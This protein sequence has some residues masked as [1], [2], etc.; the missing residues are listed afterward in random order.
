MNLDKSLIETENPNAAPIGT[1]FGLF[2]FGDANASK[3]FVI[4]LAN[5]AHFL[6]NRNME[7]TS[8]DRLH[9]FPKAYNKI[10][11]IPTFAGI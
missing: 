6:Y 8:L 4:T 9:L 1:K 2:L 10:N 3:I 7:M 11:L 5:L